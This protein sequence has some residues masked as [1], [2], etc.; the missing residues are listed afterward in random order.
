MFES[1]FLS[2]IS[3][4]IEKNHLNNKCELIKKADTAHWLRVG[5]I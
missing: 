3:E 2:V 1:I 4:G 5:N